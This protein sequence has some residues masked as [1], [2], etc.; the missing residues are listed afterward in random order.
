MPPKEVL[1]PAMLQIELDST[2]QLSERRLL[3][4]LKFRNALS[5]KTWIRRSRGSQLVVQVS[6][7]RNA[8]RGY[9]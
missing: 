4:V 8:R 1:G 3:P 5:R 2:L 7:G 6:R 9:K